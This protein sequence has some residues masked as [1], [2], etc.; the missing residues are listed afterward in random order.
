MKYSLRTTLII[1]KPFEA[2]VVKDPLSLVLPLPLQRFRPP[3]KTEKNMISTG[4][5]Y[6]ISLLITLGYF[7][8]LVTYLG[9][10]PGGKTKTKVERRKIS[11][12]MTESG[13]SVRSSNAL[14]E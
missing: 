5:F 12:G 3:R 7:T 4:N 13:C 1:H 6:K 9:S 11:R 2:K 10:G 8:K 14:S